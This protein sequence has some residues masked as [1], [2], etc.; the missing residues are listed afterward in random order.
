MQ[1]MGLIINCSFYCITIYFVGKAYWT[2]RKTGGIKGLNPAT[3]LPEERAMKK[4]GQI[5]GRAGQYIEK[6][7][8][9]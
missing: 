3:N 4:A 6:K 5:A 1:K 2:F 7:V 8:D 9:Q